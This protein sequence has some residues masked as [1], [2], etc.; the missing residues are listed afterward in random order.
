MPRFIGSEILL[1]LLS[2]PYGGGGQRGVDRE[3]KGP[4][5]PGV[6]ITVVICATVLIL[7]IIGQRRK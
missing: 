6:Q 4:M 3:R 1:I 7:T 5:T 2:W